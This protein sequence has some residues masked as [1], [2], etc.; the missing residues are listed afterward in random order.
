MTP[1]IFVFRVITQQAA[2]QTENRAMGTDIFCKA[3]E[4]LL[5]VGLRSKILRVVHPWFGENPKS[6]SMAASPVRQSYWGFI[7][8]VRPWF[9]ENQKSILSMAARYVR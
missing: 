2:T 7:S 5:N 4:S 8:V 9:G 6:I 1:A 3:W